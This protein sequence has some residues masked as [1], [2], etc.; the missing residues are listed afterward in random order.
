MA[1]LAI[2]CSFGVFWVVA[3]YQQSRVPLYSLLLSLL[4]LQ[5]YPLY[6]QILWPATSLPA[7]L[8]LAFAAL[9]A[10]R[11]GIWKFYM[12]FGVLCFGT[13]SNIYYILPLL[14]LNL[15]DE[16]ESKD[17]ANT[18]LFRILSAWG[19]GFALGYFSMLSILCLATGQLGLELAEWRQP[20]FVHSVKDIAENIDRSATY[21]LSHIQNIFSDYI[22]TWIL[23]AAMAIQFL[24]NKNKRHNI[25]AIISLAIIAA[26]YVIILPTGIIYSTRT[27]M[28]TW[29]GI[30]CLAFMA[31][32]SEGTRWL[33]LSP[34]AVLLTFSFAKQNE[35]ALAWYSTIT[36][37]WKTALLESTPLPPHQYNGL[38]FFS[39]DE[40]V[41]ASVD[42]I[43]IRYGVQQGM[44]FERLNRSKSWKP[45][46]FE[47]G[48]EKVIICNDVK[49]DY[50]NDVRPA[51]EANTRCGDGLY[52][53]YGV[54]EDGLLMAGLDVSGSVKE[55][56]P[57]RN[58]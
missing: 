40:E 23:L 54:T 51:H 29:S 47:A 33:W 22:R 58:W 50:C 14:H 13:L 32:S 10:S 16:G 27:A 1:T 5:I 9:I 18:T 39:N 2:C 34:L 6:L 4:C 53:F 48:F 56:H 37:Y 45:A 43:S 52:C 49:S 21:F 25:T 41:G 36:N 17:D 3:A 42:M 24:W 44:G 35:S 55:C 19:C 30:I 20:H 15:A 57:P 11:L 12:L 28:A 38:V 31:S 46:A 26:H 7:Y 8:L